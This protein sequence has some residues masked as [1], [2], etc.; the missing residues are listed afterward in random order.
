L[1]RPNTPAG[2]NYNAAGSDPA[3]PFSSVHERETAAAPQGAEGEATAVLPVGAGRPEGRVNEG[4]DFPPSPDFEPTEFAPLPGFGEGPY[5]AL[6]DANAVVERQPARWHAGADLGLLVLR[7]MVGGTFLAHGLR[8]MFGL[9]NGPGLDKFVAFV[10][11]DGFKYHT[12][13]AWLAGG[14]EVGA[15]ALL[16]LGLVT[17]MAAGALL[18]LISEIVVLKWKIGFFA[19]GYEYEILLAGAAFALL[20]TGPGRVSL[21]RLTPWY[22]RPVLSGFIFLVLAAGA[23]VL[24]HLVLRIKN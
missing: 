9:F 15:G 19:P 7:I 24:V 23:V 5:D 22:R 16:V 18:A 2:G 11:T 21:D 4:L 10:G 12:P 6:G 20:F 1:F 17:P 13:L 3:A 14:A 8:H